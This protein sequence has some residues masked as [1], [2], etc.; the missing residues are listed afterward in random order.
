MGMIKKTF[1]K[2]NAIESQIIS[3]KTQLSPTSSKPTTQYFPSNVINLLF[4][5]PLHL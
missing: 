2:S 4:S 5:L 1:I 3:M